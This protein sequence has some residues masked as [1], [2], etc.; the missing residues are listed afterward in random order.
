MTEGESSKTPAF[1]ML[2]VPRGSLIAMQFSDPETNPSPDEL[3]TIHM[4]TFQLLI[5]ESNSSSQGG[6][7]PLKMRQTLKSPT[8]GK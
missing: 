1:T 7:S 2:P 3:A 5:T 6:I 4:Q 8:L